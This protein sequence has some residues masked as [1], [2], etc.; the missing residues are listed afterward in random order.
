MNE[1]KPGSLEECSGLHSLAVKKGRK[2]RFL[3]DNHG[4]L[5]VNQICN[6][7]EKHKLFENLPVTKEIANI[8]LLINLTPI[9]NKGLPRIV[10]KS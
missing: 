9:H 4:Q 7:V 5:S 3:H 10:C 2:I 6:F 8:N 1:I